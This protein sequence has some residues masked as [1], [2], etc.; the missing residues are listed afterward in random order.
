MGSTAELK[1]IV[2]QAWDFF[3]GKADYEE[4]LALFQSAERM[5]RGNTPKGLRLETL[6]GMAASFRKLGQLDEAQKVLD[7]AKQRNAD[8][9]GLRCEQGWLWAERS[10]SASSDTFVAAKENAA[11]AFESAAQM[12]PKSVE[13][14]LWAAQQ[15]REARRYDRAEHTVID[16]LQHFGENARLYTERGWISFYRRNFDRALAF[17]EHALIAAPDFDIAIQGQVASL[18]ELGDLAKAKSV[19]HNAPPAVQNAPGLLTESAW[20]ALAEKDPKEAAEFF[21]TLCRSDS[22]TDDHRLHWA[23][24]LKDLGGSANLERVRELC[25][26]LLQTKLAPQAY[27]CLGN[28]AFKS[29]DTESAE[30]YLALSIALNDRLGSHE[31]L[32]R[33]YTYLGRFDDAKRVLARGLDLKPGAFSLWAAGGELFGEIGVPL[34]AADYFQRGLRL[35]GQHAPCLIGFAGALAE[36]DQVSKAEATIRNGLSALKKTDEPAVRSA[37]ARILCRRFDETRNVSCLKDALDQVRLANPRGSLPDVT[38]LEGVILYK[39]GDWRPAQAA[40]ERCVRQCT[41]ETSMQ[42][43]LS[44]LDNANVVKLKLSERQPYRQIKVAGWI[45]TAAW[46]VQLVLLWHSWW[47]TPR[48]PL[49]FW[50]QPQPRFMIPDAVQLVLATTSAIMIVLGIVLPYLGKLSF[51]GVEVELVNPNLPTGPA[52]PKGDVRFS[53]KVQS[54]GPNP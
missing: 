9:P 22:A 31:D 14:F 54:A 43:R 50:L 23:Y 18:R 10:E 13:H 47:Q 40:F 7:T 16:A 5:L 41:D 25:R 20:I 51:S 45:I 32:V 1:D 8:S 21:E 35:N 29:G 6:Q 33:L 17:F 52:G 12:E 27:N 4:S 48:S 28:T 42:V 30:D 49:L 44:A 36:L 53:E 2:E 11:G 37:L 39:K 34:Q 38:F 26:P 46:A 15:W 19:I 24:C 3:H